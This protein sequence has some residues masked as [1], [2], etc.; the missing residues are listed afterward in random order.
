MKAANFNK[1]K[2]ILSVIMVAIIICIGLI[3]AFTF[4]R[5]GSS[6]E[7][8][9]RGFEGGRFTAQFHHRQFL[10]EYFYK[11]FCEQN[12]HLFEKRD[13]KLI[14]SRY[15]LIKWYEET[16]I[17]NY[18]KCC[19]GYGWKYDWVSGWIYGWKYSW[20]YSWNVFFGNYLEQYN[21]IFFENNHLIIV[22]HLYAHHAD[23]FTVRRM[24]YQDNVLDIEF[25]RNR[26]IFVRGSRLG[27]LSHVAFIGISALSKDLEIRTHIRNPHPSQY[28]LM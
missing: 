3:T 14:T 4:I 25:Q 1:K 7:G 9:I 28:Y 6:N 16:N 18:W 26:A 8:R 22:G 27:S 2:K 15:E 11:N 24:S 20:L 19:C 10:N 5:C 13:P 17:I 23:T 21:D 12:E